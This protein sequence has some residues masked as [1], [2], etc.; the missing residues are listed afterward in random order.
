MAF[1]KTEKQKDNLSKFAYDVAKIIIAIIV[2]SP[3]VTPEPIN[4]YLFVGDL[5]VG[6]LVLSI[7]FLI[8]GSILDRREAKK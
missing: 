6:G 5:F 3:I 2:I 4:F 7:M 8:F 1:I